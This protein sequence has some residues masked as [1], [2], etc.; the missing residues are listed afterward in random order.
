MIA[1]GHHEIVLT[2]VHLGTYDG[3]GGLVGLVERILLEPGLGR[4][5]LS[6]IEPMKFPVA[7]IELAASN[8]LIAPHFHL[9]LQSGSD[10]VLKRMVR[11]YRSRDFIE[12]CRELRRGVPD[13][14]LGTDVIVGFP[15]ETDEDFEATVRTIEDCKLDYIHVFSYSDRDGTPSTRLGPKVDSTTIKKR[16]DELSRLSTRAW[17]TFLARQVGKT[18]SAVTLETVEGSVDLCRAVAANYAPLQF[19]FDGFTTP[20]R[21]VSV[22]VAGRRGRFLWGE[23]T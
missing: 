13:P 8:P 15:G 7:L 20:N 16:S 4:L 14:C 12:L 22:R 10:R 6:C 19:R 23:R 1:A 18:L 11:P 17:D 2:G 3:G 21:P 9:P 5:R